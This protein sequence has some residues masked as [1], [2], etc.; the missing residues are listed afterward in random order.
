MLP[1]HIQ[2]DRER[3]RRTVCFGKCVGE[4][5]CDIFIRQSYH[6]SFG[7]QHKITFVLTC[8]LRSHLPMLQMAD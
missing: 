1:K 3:E 6:R 5:V 7:Y 4:R 2:S 8:T